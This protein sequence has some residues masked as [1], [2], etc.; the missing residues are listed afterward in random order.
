MRMKVLL[1]SYQYPNGPDAKEV[2]V[3]NPPKLFKQVLWKEVED[4]VL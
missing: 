3:S 1:S 2:E 4:G